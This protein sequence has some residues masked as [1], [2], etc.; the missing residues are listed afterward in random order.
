MYFTHSA[1]IIAFAAALTSARAVTPSVAQ[2]TNDI[3]PI[4]PG[5]GEWVIGDFTSDCE[6]T[7]ATESCFFDF[8]IRRPIGGN[9]I[10]TYELDRDEA[11]D[12]PAFAVTDHVGVLCGSLTV[13]SGWDGKGRVFS[14]A[15]Y[16]AKKIIWAGYDQDVL[17]EAAV[18]DRR[19][20]V[21]DLPDGAVALSGY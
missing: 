4:Y 15:D 16:E 9:A 18:P 14:I 12:T 1:I 19:L 20:F 8:T 7:V 21:H 10:C 11:T 2:R 5:P 17:D 13:R 6:R 3:Y